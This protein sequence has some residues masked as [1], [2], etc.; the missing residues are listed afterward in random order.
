MT[1]V[2]WLSLLFTDAAPADGPVPRTADSRSVDF[3]S[4][5][6]P[7]LTKAGCN[8]GACHGAA[9]G[10]G[11]MHLSLLGSDPSADYETI[12]HALEGRRINLARPEKSLFYSK[13][14]GNLD[15]GGGDILEAGGPGADRLLAWIQSGVSRGQRRKLTGMTVTPT[16]FLGQAVPA[17]ARIRVSAR[18]DDGREEDVTAWSVLTPT[19]QSSIRIDQDFVAH[20]ARSGQHTVIVRFL[21][22]V[23]PIQFNLAVAAHSVDLSDEPRVNFI[24]DEVLR[25]LNDLRI[26]VS[27]QATDAAFVRRVCLDLTGRL[28][29]P[30]LIDTYL[31]DASADKRGRLV[32]ALLASDAFADYWTLRFARLLKLHSLPNETEA[33]TVYAAWIR[34]EIRDGTGFDQVA[35]QLLT[36]T[37]DSHQVGPAN[38]GRMVSDARGQAELVGQAF[39]GIRLGCANCHNHPLDKWTQ[40]DYHGLAAVFARLDRGRVVQVT[41]RGAVTNPRTGE[42]AVPRIPGIRSLPV[43]GDTREAFARWLTSAECRYFSRATVNRLWRAMFGRGLV[44]PTDDLRETNPATHPELLDRLAEDFTSNGN[45]IRRTLKHIALSSTY[46]RSDVAIAGN[47]TDDRFYS[48]AIRREL[49]PEV[50]ADAIA[51]VTGVPNDYAGHAKGTRAV[52]LVDPLSPA[53]VLDVLGRC[54]RAAGCDEG[55]K[56]RTTLSAQLHLLNGDLVNRKLTSPEGRLHRMIS[57]GKSDTQIVTEFYRQG[58]GRSP[59]PAELV[60]WQMLLKP[61]GGTERLEDF[62]WSLLNSREFAENH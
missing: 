33:A 48:H 53:P 26:P 14:T 57:A 49:E 22:R 54:S 15:H 5:I 10:R 1:F 55:V 39:L 19:D 41:G 18:F 31:A 45:S 42:P 37:G 4:E 56:P 9:A 59:S 27:P 21:D 46:G 61:E 8:S 3:D 36:A 32:D 12:V 43:D 17:S 38:F 23:V 51:D 25:M 52:T 47:E 6:I 40:D 16:R 11:G 13:P 30:E 58:L 60:R 62:V 28:P 2:V 24:D 29:E 50:L 44:D 20:I 34:K 35:Y 7:L